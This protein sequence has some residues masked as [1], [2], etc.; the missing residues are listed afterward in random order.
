MPMQVMTTPL[1]KKV[2]ATIAKYPKNKLIASVDMD[3]VKVNG[4]FPDLSKA[5]SVEQTSTSFYIIS[6]SNYNEIAKVRGLKDKIKLKDNN[7]AVVFEQIL[8]MTSEY[9]YIGKTITINENNEKL[10]LKVVDFK[11]YSL[12]N[13]GMIRYSCCC[14]G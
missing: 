13:S 12:P 8:N 2:E 5:S 3:F 4:Q 7:E 14:I 6:E 10:P 1:D 9:D 11:D